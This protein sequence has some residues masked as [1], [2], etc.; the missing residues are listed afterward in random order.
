M[1][2]AQQNSSA[3]SLHANRQSALYF[4]NRYRSRYLAFHSVMEWQG[5]WAPDQTF[6]AWRDIKDVISAAAT[7]TT[8]KNDQVWIQ[9]AKRFQDTNWKIADGNHNQID[10]AAV[11]HHI[12]IT[13]MWMSKI[14]NVGGYFSRA[15]STYESSGLTRE[16]RK[17]LN[18]MNSCHLWKVKEGC[19]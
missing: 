5:S 17:M 11:W 15:T 1:D 7:Q 9:W 3:A 10:H 16:W 8:Q 2:E 6:T 19:D 18:L 14:G 13:S 12:S 4:I